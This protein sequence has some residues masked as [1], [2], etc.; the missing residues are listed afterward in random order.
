MKMNSDCIYVPF[1]SVRC[2]IVTSTSGQDL[3]VFKC[4]AYPKYFHVYI[5][6]SNLVVN[7]A[8]LSHYGVTGLGPSLPC[9]S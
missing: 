9:D 4:S 7:L 5:I 6:L 1:S 8:H 3:H 2:L